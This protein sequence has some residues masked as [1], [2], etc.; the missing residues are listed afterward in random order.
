MGAEKLELNTLPEVSQEKG[1]RELSQ[2]YFG[3]K[4]LT[5]WA[6][7][8]ETS[9]D[10]FNTV[11]N[12]KGFIT[13][14]QGNHSDLMAYYEIYK[15][16]NARAI[17]KQDYPI[18]L[19]IKKHFGL[20]VAFQCLNYHFQDIAEAY[21]DVKEKLR[22]GEFKVYVKGIKKLL[23]SKAYAHVNKGQMIHNSFQVRSKS[24]ETAVARESELR[25][26]DR[27]AE[28]EANFK[29]DIF[30]LLIPKT[31]GDL[32][33]IG[34]AQRHCVGTIAMK[35][36]ERVNSGQSIIFAMYK[37]KLSDGFCVE[38]DAFGEMIQAH[39]FGNRDLTSMELLE[40]GRTMGDIFNSKSIVNT[41]LAWLASNITE[42]V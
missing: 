16:P 35:Y 24:L 42:G 10:K 26:D 41:D 27:L 28:M 20:K 14:F 11:R 18:Y 1:L 19:E 13:F 40:L 15:V 21:R 36:H 3:I 6:A 17:F 4:G 2:E 7:H 25:V 8:V 32:A 12:I 23:E 39:G 30:K 29:S 34:N 31:Q 38:L 9:L 37:E 33:D 22:E 5:E